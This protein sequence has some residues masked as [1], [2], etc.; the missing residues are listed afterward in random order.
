MTSGHELFDAYNKKYFRSRL[1]TYKVRFVPFDGTQVNCSES[2]DTP[3]AKSILS[4]SGNLCRV[5]LS[6]IGSYSM[7]CATAR[8]GHTSREGSARSFVGSPRQARNGRA[9]KP[10]STTSCRLGT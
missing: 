6:R 7:R 3:I 1:P 2:T 9:K 5:R 8:E 10:T 4:L